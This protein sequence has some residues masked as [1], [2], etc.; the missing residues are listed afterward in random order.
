[1]VLA[2]CG[3]SSEPDP[4]PA[5]S[6]TT[7]GVDGGDRATATLPSTVATSDDIRPPAHTALAEALAELG[8]AYEFTSEVRTMTGDQVSISG[9]RV[10]MGVA[11]QLEAGDAVVDVIS[12]EGETWVRTQGTDEWNASE[13][14]TSGD[15]LG[16]LSAPI[17]V[18]WD[19]EEPNRLHARYSG[20][21]I[22]LG[23]DEVVFV[24][25]DL[26]GDVIT[27]RSSTD[28]I[29]LSTRLTRAPGLQPIAPP[30]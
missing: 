20:T 16:P 29:S 13:G 23:T 10:G 6:P 9:S 2:G 21:S 30:A 28:D 7:G 14:D 19:A 15:P 12:V 27:F 24:T 3:G 17:E 18:G 5:A 22:G 8:T 4:G 26:S 25:I 1:M 11:F